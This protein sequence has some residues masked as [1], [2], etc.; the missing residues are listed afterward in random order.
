MGEKYVIFSIHVRTVV[1]PQKFRS[2][3]GFSAVCVLYTIT[4]YVFDS[5][6]ETSLPAE[7]CRLNLQP[8][9]ACTGEHSAHQEL[10]PA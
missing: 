6:D 5:P 4:C 9:L 1:S 10:S 2:S 3:G 7:T 8:L